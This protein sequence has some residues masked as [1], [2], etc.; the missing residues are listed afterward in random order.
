MPDGH[1]AVTDYGTGPLFEI[2]N[3][4]NDDLPPE[5]VLVLVNRALDESMRFCFLKLI[6]KIVLIKL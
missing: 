3:E 6:F 5:K 1:F 4:Y 2:I